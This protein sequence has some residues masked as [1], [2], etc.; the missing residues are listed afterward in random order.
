MKPCLVILDADAVIHLHELGRWE[1]VMNSYLLLLPETVA[2]GECRFY[3]DEYGH[4]ITIPMKEYISS[5]KIRVESALAEEIADVG[6]RLGRSF[7]SLHEL[8][9]GEMEA[10]AILLR[11]DRNSTSICTGDTAAVTA[12]CCLDCAGNAISL[13]KLLSK[14]GFSMKVH[15][16]FTED[17]LRS[18]LKRG[19]EFRI[20]H[21]I[22]L[23]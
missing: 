2:L 1:E 6:N 3:E 7:S 12:L 23:P 9:L 22:G 13:E 18:K 14:C 16:N 10:M 8:H 17:A 19:R 21:G 5:G 11:Q 4:R 15:R 20:T